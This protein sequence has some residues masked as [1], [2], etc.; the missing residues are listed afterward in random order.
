MMIEV[1]HIIDI[2]ILVVVAYA[3]YSINTLA[4]LLNEIADKHNTFV[5]DMK[6]F[7]EAVVEDFQEVERVL[8]ERQ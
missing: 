5:Q 7:S 6:E 1:T 2:G 4:G 8:N 3:V